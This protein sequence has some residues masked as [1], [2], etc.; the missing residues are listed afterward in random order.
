MQH[1]SKDDE[2]ILSVMEHHANIVPVAFFTGAAWVLDL[3]GSIVIQ[4]AI[5][6][7]REL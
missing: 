7:R 5:W 3:N 4:M 2:I 1:L 6:I